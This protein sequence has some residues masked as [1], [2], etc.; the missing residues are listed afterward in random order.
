MPSK[1]YRQYLNSGWDSSTYLHHKLNNQYPKDYIK[2]RLTQ[3]SFQ[4]YTIQVPMILGSKGGPRRKF[5]YP[6]CPNRWSSSSYHL[7]KTFRTGMVKVY[8]PYNQYRILPKYN[9]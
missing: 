8:P 5:G 3:V 9:K 7:N 1:K 6:P 4:D 2:N